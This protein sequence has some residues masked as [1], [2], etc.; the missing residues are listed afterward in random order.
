MRDIGPGAD[1]RD[2]C[3]QRVDIAI[4]AVQPLHLAIHP[5]GRQAPTIGQMAKN[6][7]EQPCMC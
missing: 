4:G 3:D 2:P 1:M 6:L 7:R 5:I